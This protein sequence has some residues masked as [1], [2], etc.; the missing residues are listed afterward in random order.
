M[1]VAAGSKH[2]CRMTEATISSLSFWPRRRT[3]KKLWGGCRGLGRLSRQSQE[4]DLSVVWRYKRWGSQQR[5]LWSG[6][7]LLAWSSGWDELKQDGD[8]V[9]QGLLGSLQDSE[10]RV[11]GHTAAPWNAAC[12]PR[13]PLPSILECPDP[14]RGE[15]AEDPGAQQV[16]PAASMSQV[17]NYSM[18]LYVWLVIRV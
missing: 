8:A 11:A 9:C 5:L 13:F 18:L 1:G 10:L 14:S 17:A 16:A 3:R 7:V 6:H 12:S 4:R 15:D 2:T